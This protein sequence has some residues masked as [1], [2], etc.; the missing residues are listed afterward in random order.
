MATPTSSVASGWGRK[1]SR[2]RWP[3]R[4]EP[5]TIVPSIGRRASFPRAPP[6]RHEERASPV[7]PLRTSLRLM[8]LVPPPPLLLVVADERLVVEAAWPR[9]SRAPHAG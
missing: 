3:R 1:P 2:S 4:W 5:P 8:A 7:R 6:R 9:V